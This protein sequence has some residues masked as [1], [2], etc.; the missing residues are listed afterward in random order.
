MN[1][2]LE[3]I[4]DILPPMAPPSSTNITWPV[5]LLIIFLLCAVGIY[6][7]R[8]NRQQL[9]RLQQK[10][11]RKKINQRQLAFELARLVTQ[12]NHSPGNASWTIFHQQLQAACFSRNGLHENEM[13]KLL[14]SAEQWI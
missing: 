6:F 14:S 3:K 11:L 2:E 4:A 13:K 9:K 7:Y 12:K 1:I 5:I 10:Y 8:S